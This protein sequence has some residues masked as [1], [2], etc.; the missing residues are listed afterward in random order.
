MFL[1]IS[2]T[3]YIANWMDLL[4]PRF[5]SASSF[6]PNFPTFLRNGSESCFRPN[7]IY[8]LYRH[9]LFD[10]FRPRLAKQQLAPHDR[11]TSN[12]CGPARYPRRCNRQRIRKEKWNIAGI[13][14]YRGFI[15]PIIS[16]CQRAFDYRPT[17]ASFHAAYNV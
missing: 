4:I 16:R 10:G 1:A 7:F 15:G 11:L 9:T 6:F 5:P 12:R 13:S 14:R 8:P 17:F 2:N 3:R